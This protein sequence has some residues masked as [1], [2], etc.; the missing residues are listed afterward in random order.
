MVKWHPGRDSRFRLA[1]LCTGILFSSLTL[2]AQDALNSALSLNGV[3]QKQNTSYTE[4]PLD[5]LHLGPVQYTASAYAGVEFDD[6]IN[7]TQYHPESDTI[8]SSGLNLGMYWP[9]TQQSELDLSTQ[10]GYAGYLK[11]PS[12]D[13]LAVAPGSALTWTVSLASVSLT[14]FDQFS[15]AQITTPYASISNTGQIPRVDNVAGIRLNWQPDGWQFQAG[16][17]HETYFS[18]SDAFTYLNRSSE[19]FYASGAW[20]FSQ[21][22]GQLGLEASANMTGY[23]VSYQSGNTS[24]S[25]GPYLQWAVTPHTSAT[26]RGGPTIYS[27]DGA[28]GGT[29]ASNLISYYVE[30]DFSDQLTDFL[31]QE[32]SVQRSVSLGYNLG[33]NYTEQYTVNYSVNWNATQWLSTSLELTYENGQQPLP[34]SYDSIFGPIIYY[35]QENY[36]RYGFSPSLRYQL[37]KSFSASLNYSYW[38]R[39]SNLAGN[40]YSDNTVTLQFQYAF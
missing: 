9:A 15:V 30:L 4:L 13:Y 5:T 21:S 28:T 1:G 32:L 24:Y 7:L 3:L 35:V 37:T 25:L 31:S 6:N 11:Y 20:L 38:Q 39:F 22:E 34:Q 26:V 40:S 8:L 16:Y 27:F 10:I 12:N 14:V 36:S 23:E 18:T 29:A 33:I 19:D 2:R 17:S